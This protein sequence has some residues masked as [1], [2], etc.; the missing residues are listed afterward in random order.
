[1][2][3]EG[4][5]APGSFF[6][7]NFS[8]ADAQTS[9]SAK[10]T[11]AP[12][13]INLESI[14]LQ[15]RNVTVLQG[16]ALLPINV[17]ALWQAQPWSSV[18]DAEAPLKLALSAQGMRLHDA[19]LLT[20]RDRA[21]SGDLE[22]KVSAAGNLSAAT[23]MGQ[24]HL[25]KGQAALGGLSLDNVEA[26]VSLLGQQAEIERL[27]ARANLSDFLAGDL[28]GKGF[29][30]WKDPAFIASGFEA[31]SRKAVFTTAHGLHFVSDLD[32]TLSKGE[33]A[34]RVSG[35]ARFN[36]AKPA[37]TLDP[38]AIF[39][40]A[41]LAL[42][43]APLAAD[44]SINIDCKGET[45]LRGLATPGKAELA[46][47]I[48]GSP[49]D[50]RL[51]GA[52]ELQSVSLAALGLNSTLIPWNSNAFLIDRGTVYF[53]EPASRGVTL[54]LRCSASVSGYQLFAS[55]L[56]SPVEG[57]VALWSDP[58]LPPPRLAALTS[59]EPAWQM[60]GAPRAAALPG[61]HPLTLGVAEQPRNPELLFGETTAWPSLP[62]GFEP[63]VPSLI[64]S[65]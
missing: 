3:A 39:K 61:A 27:A 28:L 60:T 11:A 47:K 13:T 15:H 32:L 59:R 65:P 54:S 64:L 17:W 46:F 62:W 22:M 30:D 24:M 58:P 26:D 41:R 56:G 38:G 63:D 43:A 10:V 2:A 37:E 7:S 49:R 29:F 12:K 53:N 8:L 31:H 48:A 50:L 14:K 4:T 52:A 1:M 57:T 21:I 19:A 51:I 9:F 33:T 5:Y 35:L 18:F 6:L 45:L 20:G 25:R 16:D 55:I 34:L 44:S 23:V 42:G 40:G 36:G